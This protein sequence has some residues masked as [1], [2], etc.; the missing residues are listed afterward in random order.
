VSWQ[1]QE[2]GLG[3]PEILIYRSILKSR[4]LLQNGETGNIPS[5]IS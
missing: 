4:K 5:C 3:V 2:L 1:K